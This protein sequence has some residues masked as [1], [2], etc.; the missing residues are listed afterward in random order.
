MNHLVVL[1][2]IVH[3]AHEIRE[4]VEGNANKCI[5]S[6]AKPSVLSNCGLRRRENNNNTSFYSQRHIS[7]FW[8]VM[9]Y[10]NISLK[11]TSVCQHLVFEKSDSDIM[12]KDGFY[13]FPEPSDH[14]NRMQMSQGY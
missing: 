12:K 14:W 11:G 13:E 10:L 9:S 4:Y 6:A 5:T 8:C 7:G 2:H 3:L 1:P